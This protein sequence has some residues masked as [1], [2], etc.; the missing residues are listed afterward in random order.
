M[1]TVLPPQSDSAARTRTNPNSP[2]TGNAPHNDPALEKVDSQHG[3]D[4]ART[5]FN[6]AARGERT[7]LKFEAEFC[8]DDGRT[9]FATTQWDL[10]SATIKDETGRALFEQNDCE[11]PSSWS[12]LATNV[13]VSKYFYGD[14]NT[15]G[16]RERSVR[17]LVHRVTR[18]LSDWG[19]A[20]GYFDTPEDGERF[21]RDLTWLCLHQH[22]AFN[23]PVWF[24]VGLHAQYGVSGSKCN[25][26]W[27][28]AQQ[29]TAQPE[30]PYEY[31]QG[32][33]CFIQSVDDNME[34][35]MR[36][37]CS[38]AMLFKFGSGTGT[39][40][41][42]IRSQRE[43]LSGGGTPSGPLSFMRVYDSIAGVVK[44]GGK[45]RRAAKM[46]SLKV[47]H[48]DILEFIEC[49]WAEE[50][51]AHALIR[52]GY[53]S[54][55]NGEAY[56]SV[57]FQNANLSVRLTDD[58]METVR[59]GEQWQ[60]RWITDKPTVAAPQYDARELLNKMAEC[61]WHCGDPGVQYDTTI[62]QWHTCPN[63]GAINASNPCVTGDTLVS[64]STGYRRIIDLVGKT[65]EIINGSGKVVSIDR[66]FKTGTKPVYRLRT[67]G[68]Y[69]IKLTADHRVW[70]ENRGDVP[71]CEL[72]RDD[73]VKLETVGFGDDFVPAA[74]GELL[75]AALG[76]GCITTG[77]NDQDFLFVSLGEHE[78][79][80][81]SRL[82]E[83]LSTIKQWL[84]LEDGRANRGSEVTTTATGVRV[85]TSVSAVLAK[86]RE[87]AVL[88]EGSAQKRLTD[89]VYSLDRPSQTALLQG[90]FTA[91]G[92]VANYGEKSPYVSL[93]STSEVMLEQVQ[94]LLLGYGIK[95]KIYRNRRAMNQSTA[96]LP[97]AQGGEKEYHV[98]QMHSLRISKRS[99]VLFQEH[100]GFL[101]ES[102]KNEKLA[103]MNEAIASYADPMIDRVDSI[104]P[105][106]VED[107]F[108]LTEPESHHFVAG[109][110][111]IHNCSE[112]MF[113]DDTACNLSSVNLMKFVGKDGNMDV[114]RFRAA[115]RTFFIAQEI[116]VDHASYPTEPIARNSHMYRPLG[117][118]Y[119]NL[120][121][122]IMT[123]GLAYDSD[124]A[125]GLCGSLTALLHGEAN[126]TSAEMAAVVGPFDGYAGNEEP[127]NRVMQMHRDACDEINDDGPPELKTAAT[128]LWD[129]VTQIGKKHGFRNAQAT[130]LAPTGTISFMMD[131]DTT[132]I[133]PDIA[134]VKY[135][136]LAGGGMLKIV[137]QTVKLG[138]KTLGYDQIAIDEIL[139]FV[140][141]NDTIEGA[142]GLNDEHLSVFDCAFK[143][144]GGVRSIN[145]RAHVTMMAAAQPFL[146]G[147]ISKTV[148]MPTDVTPEDIADA[149]F[150]G[151][152]LGLKA[153]AIYRDGSKQ[154]QPLNTKQGDSK[155]AGEVRVETKTVEKIVYKP[156][157]ERLPDTRQSL[158][159]K[160]SIAGHE[161]YLCVGLYPDGRP[162]EMFITM[163]KE[164][165]TIGGIMDSFGTA[166]SI[167]LQYGVPLDVIVNK[168]SHT[169]F[170]PMGHT[171]NKDIRIAKS[172]V[173][174]I[175]RW[176]GIT[177]MSGHD[178]VASTSQGNGPE[179]ATGTDVLGGVKVDKGVA[180]PAASSKS[181]LAQE[182]NSVMR[183]LKNDASAAV[184]I[185]ERAILMASMGGSS[186]SH[187]GGIHSGGSA[188]VELG[189]Q[190]EQ[191]SRFQTDAPSCDNCGS[192][193]VRNGNCYLCHNCGNSMGCS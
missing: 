77:A 125:R 99:R 169:R 58:F 33:A 29:T 95:S 70:T 97:D 27:D 21:Y 67:R 126:R 121:S 115:A 138:L 130:V 50:K 118:G 40:L 68:G 155:T 11:I 60:T 86:L 14:P 157:R 88:D 10:R 139:K 15:E 96:L 188:E 119:S 37:A 182:T 25:W 152:K 79:G 123:S 175:A 140:D 177:F 84:Q 12:Q 80:V 82:Q 2:A 92:T 30:N 45:T 46:Q 101:P 111:V 20:D 23:S 159:H 81:A 87:F 147:A 150:W 4:Y 24:N 181:A 184:A 180:A 129:E 43:K 191:F 48:P 72:T 59:K 62:N 73:V 143:P 34:D 124:A 141:E 128:E 19:L 57:C 162:G 47:W 5:K 71:A 145:W 56:S 178:H 28:A 146:S 133:E 85:G 160:F 183:D 117:L 89:Q 54:N 108:D 173:D 131:C 98:A 32:S 112:Y 149:Y 192:I 142:P 167:A 103:S 3:V 185:A 104:E 144:A 187:N 94:L 164:G 41:S 179:V 186:G 38:E 154:S 49:K 51:K 13:V 39:D 93:D 127:M 44:S 151:W 163:A 55:F 9:P 63:S 8:P 107:V 1:S 90:L 166:L 190:A 120:G 134:L 83:G 42:T 52:E 165:S 135:K 176:L 35:I 16:E 26:H 17:Q 168:F 105:C 171:T 113:L 69:N 114:E 74:F 65:A 31:P 136:Q 53:E 7:G 158:T 137:N 170:E 109:G 76:D 148:N 153:I 132:G 172:V 193:T 64:T 75:G 174:Y 91:D 22:G 106:G 100:I 102:D 78:R 66:I 122:V 110:V 18:T 61:A 6:A 116:L 36:L 161:G 156:S 189:G